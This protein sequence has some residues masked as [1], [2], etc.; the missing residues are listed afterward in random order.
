MRTK[1]KKVLAVLAALAAFAATAA[2]A[3]S[4]G[5]LNSTSLGADQTV[6]AACDSNGIDISYTNTYNATSNAYETTAVTLSGV[7]ASCDTKSYQVALNDG[8][9]TLFNGSGT[10]TLVTGSQTIAVS[11]AV[12]AQAVTKAALVITG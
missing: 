7:D 11:P 2:S 4:L 1:N 10:V 5:G 12:D 6:V 8:A 9:A 3:A